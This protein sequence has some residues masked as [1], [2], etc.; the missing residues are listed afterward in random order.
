[1][2]SCVMTPLKEKRQKD[3]RDSLTLMSMNL[4]MG[5]YHCS[6][7]TLDSSAPHRNTQSRNVF[8]ARHKAENN[9]SVI[10]GDIILLTFDI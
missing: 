5:S 1:M 3:A 9:M 7:T 2:V 10:F 4:C 6:K 8:L